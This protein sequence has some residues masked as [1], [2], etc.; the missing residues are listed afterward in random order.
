VL[1]S[2][3]PLRLSVNHPGFPYPGTVR[4][5]RR[6]D[7]KRTTDNA[8]PRR[9]VGVSPPVLASGRRQPAGPVLGACP[10]KL[11]LAQDSLGPESSEKN[12]NFRK[13]RLHPQKRVLSSR[14]IDSTAG[15]NCRRSLAPQEL[16][17]GFS[18]PRRVR[19]SWGN[20]IYRTAFS[21][22][23]DPVVGRVGNRSDGK[24][25][26]NGVSSRGIPRRDSKQRT[27]T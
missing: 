15:A 2:F 27:G 21:R 1:K 3:A 12:R 19:A 4:A 26:E 8:A 13:N 14:L 9:T 10:T 25:H 17:A 6:Q 5:R 16:A 7:A 23:R 24:G 18:A 11:P 20:K 22:P